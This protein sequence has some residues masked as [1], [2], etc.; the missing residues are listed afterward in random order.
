MN[1]T[2]KE[3]QKHNVDCLRGP[4]DWIQK[5]CS[6]PVFPILVLGGPIDSPCFYSTGSWGG[7]KMWNSCRSLRTGL[8][9]TALIHHYKP[10]SVASSHYCVNVLK[11]HLYWHWPCKVKL[12]LLSTGRLNVH[13]RV[14][15]LME[16]HKEFDSLTMCKCVTGIK[17]RAGLRDHISF[18]V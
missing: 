9:K 4:E 17:A 16:R 5:H 8:G 12:I 13:D 2:I 6:N 18:K 7:T 14:S 1:Q 3:N 11:P 15:H 10:L